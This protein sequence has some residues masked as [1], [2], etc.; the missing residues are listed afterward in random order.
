MAETYLGLLT[1]VNHLG[2]EVTLTLIQD[3][4]IGL[5]LWPIAKRKMNRRLKREHMILDNEHGV[6]HRDVDITDAGGFVLEH[7]MMVDMSFHPRNPF[8][9]EKNK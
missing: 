9:V 6:T 3:G 8:I 5:F 2:F 4:I 7:G 1:D